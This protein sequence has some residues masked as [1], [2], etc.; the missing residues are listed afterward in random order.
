MHG[1]FD[2]SLKFVLTGEGGY[3]DHPNDLGGET[4]YG[5]SKRSHPDE[6]IPNLTLERAGEI[7]WADYWNPISGD[8]LPS[9]IDYVTFDSAVNHGPRTAGS[10]LQRAVN[11]M[12]Y[13]L[14]VDGLIGPV[15]IQAV[16][17]ANPE[18]LITDILRERDIFYR[19]IVAQDPSQEVFF[20]GWLARLAKV[21]VN[22][23]EFTA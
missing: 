16:L 14:T 13:G 2:K 10:L 15:T 19:K 11:R 20:R 17:W 9:G 18:I 7:Y 6:D 22:V 5:I 8:D 23:R 4:K 3:I 1:N 21:A 12:A